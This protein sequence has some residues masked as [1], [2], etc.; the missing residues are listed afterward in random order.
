MRSKDWRAELL[1]RRA[2]SVCVC[3]CVC[4]CVLRSARAVIMIVR[5]PVIACAGKQRWT[6][7]T[8]E[9]Q[10]TWIVYGRR[11][12]AAFQAA[13]HFLGKLN[14]RIQAA[15]PALLEARTEAA[16]GRMLHLQ[17]RLQDEPELQGELSC[18]SLRCITVHACML[19]YPLISN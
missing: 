7:L 16:Q 5:M 4:V 10:Q 6:G 2:R 15:F 3:V 8:K 9:Q 17:L 18:I 11:G 12:A 13:G 1:P 14:A 19:I